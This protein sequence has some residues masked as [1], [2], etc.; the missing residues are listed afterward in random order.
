M[1]KEVETYR[2]VVYPW[3][4][5]HMGHMNVQ[6]YTARFDEATWH[7]NASIGLT[8]AYFKANRRGMAAVEQRT[9][10]LRELHAGALIRIT[11]ELVELKGKM[12]RF[13]HRMYD[14][15]TGDEVA[16]SELVALFI[17]T[18]TRRAVPFPEEILQRAA[19]SL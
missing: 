9:R 18:G 5:D 11:S 16:S 14:D 19:Q 3:Q 12:A 15:E 6:F 10:Y 8:P 7:L 13:I 4:I 1:A 2:G 17:D